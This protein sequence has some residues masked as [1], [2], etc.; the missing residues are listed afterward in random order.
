M[1]KKYKPSVDVDFHRFLN[2]QTLSLTR[3]ESLNSSVDCL[4]N[5]QEQFEEKKRDQELREVSESDQS[6]ESSQG[7]K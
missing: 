4:E 2:D 6:S 7:G 3:K 5:I 1:K